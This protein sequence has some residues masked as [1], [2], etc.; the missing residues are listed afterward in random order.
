MDKY[1]N[2]IKDHFTHEPRFN[3]VLLKANKIVNLNEISEK[4]KFKIIDL[5]KLIIKGDIDLERIDGYTDLLNILNEICNNV[6]EKGATFLNL[7]LLLSTL[8]KKKRKQFF[9][10]ILQKTFPNPALFV[11]VLF[12]NE[13]LDVKPQEFNYAKVIELEE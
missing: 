9:E 12:N 8:N 10:R 4:L 11:T 6:K 3:I 5:K 13:V 1:Y 7:D 2:K